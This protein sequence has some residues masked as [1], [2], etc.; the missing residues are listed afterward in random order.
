ML[1]HFLFFLLGCFFFIFFS[2]SAVSHLPALIPKTY[3][4]TIA[5]TIMS[6]FYRSRSV[7]TDVL[8]AGFFFHQV[9][10]LIFGAHLPIIKLFGWVSNSLSGRFLKSIPFLL[11]DFAFLLFVVTT[12]KHCM[13]PFWHPL[14]TYYLL[15]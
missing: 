5:T 4:S 14:G 12:I 15:L 7:A 10:V 6:L 2:H 1:F 8:N 3:S 13:Y 11:Q 9:Y